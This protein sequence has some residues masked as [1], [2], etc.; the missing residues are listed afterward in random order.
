MRQRLSLNGLW[1][2]ALP[3]GPAEKKAVPSSYLCVGEAHY[4]RTFDLPE[5]PGRWS[6]HFDGVAHDGEVTV[7]GVL[8]GN[9][10]PYVPFAFD[11]TGIAR[12]GVN[13]V[14]VILRDLNAVYGPTEGWEYYGGLVRDVYLECKPDV[15]ITS[16]QWTC[17]LSEG[18][19]HAQGV[20]RVWLDGPA[21]VRLTLARNGVAVAQAAQAGGPEQPVAFDI[22]VD[23]PDLWSPDHPALYTLTLT[24]DSGDCV[25]QEVGF[26]EFVA[27]GSKFHLNGQE[28]FL[29]GVCRHDCWGAD[30]GFTMSR[31]QMEQDMAMIK[32]LGAN[33]V[34]LVHY[35]HHPYILE[36]AD[37]LGLMVSGEPGLWWNDL[38]DPV[39]TDAALEV[40]RRLVLRDRNH[41]SVIFWLTFNECELKGDYLARA[42]AICQECDPTRMVSGANCMP[43]PEARD[44]YDK[45]GFDFYTQ[46]PYGHHP[47]D[48]VMGMGR[49]APMAEVLSVFS[50]KPVVFT[51]WGGW[52]VRDNPALMRGFGDALIQF[53]HAQAPE[54]NLAGCSYWCW[55]DYYQTS[56]GP[57]GCIADGIVAEGLTD[58]NRKP[59]VILDVLRDIFFEIDH[60]PVQPPVKAQVL[61]IPRPQG[62]ALPLDLSALIAAPEQAAAFDA[63]R[64]QH[65]QLPLRHQVIRN[66]RG[67]VLP[68]DLAQIGGLPVRLQAGRPLTLSTQVGKVCLPVGAAAASVYFIGQTTYAVGYP[69]YG[70]RTALARYTLHYADGGRSYHL[71]ENGLDLSAASMIHGPS[72][73]DPR[74]V[75]APRC[76]VL[77]WD[78]DWETYQVCYQ[79]IAADPTRVLDRIEVEMLDADTCALLYGVT[80][81]L[82]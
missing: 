14:Q 33:F 13:E 75:R 27:V 41:A 73:I 46:H 17:T 31:A 37:R 77:P 38:E 2:W 50:G 39:V 65:E 55:N 74:S 63:A 48:S 68:E 64:A 28:I 61:P 82:A 76:L 20:C 35:P 45:S 57:M 34:R 78:A 7:N 1:D 25:T 29:K 18:Y 23:H 4:A 69:A 60:P 62:A 70:V 54:P 81:E 24:T 9:L 36:L 56:R 66:P 26:R 8:V 11:L 47:L 49:P 19:T 21:Q 72:R 71:Q 40:L 42:R 67:P 16:T 44:F 58:V 51:E 22:P 3:G 15:A 5:G 52:W 12:P 30:Q 79:R 80:V 6:L 53:A 59:H 43:A 32:R 10:L